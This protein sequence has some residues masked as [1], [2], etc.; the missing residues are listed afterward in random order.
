MTALR[1]PRILGRTKEAGMIP[2]VTNR[3]ALLVTVAVALVGIVDAAI[4]HSYDLLAVFTIVAVLQFMLI[5]RMSSRRPDVPIR[6]DLVR[7]FRDRAALEGENTEAMIDRALAAYR[8]DLVG[9]ART[10]EIADDRR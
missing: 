5:I 2:T 6:A 10:E 8:D 3:G 7:W 4:G 9:P 1:V